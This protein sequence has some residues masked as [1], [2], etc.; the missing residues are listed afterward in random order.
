MFDNKFTHFL[1]RH[2]NFKIG[3][4]SGIVTGSIV[5]VINIEFGF[6][7]AF[8]G[9]IK[10]F[11]FNVLMAGYNTKSCEKIAKYIN[12]NTLSL[13]SASVIPTLQAFIIL[14]SIHYFGGT[15]RP[16]DSTLWQAVANL[17]FFLFMALIYRNVIHVG[18]I[19]QKLSS[20]LKF[21]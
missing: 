19:S 15:P 9:F 14:F 17:I 16:M 11:V 13:V 10:Q 12:N 21:K 4:L 7:L 2:I 3:V 18:N 1:N 5:F 20:I 8:G 6:W